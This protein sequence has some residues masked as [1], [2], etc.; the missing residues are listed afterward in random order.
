VAHFAGK[1][2]A[3]L[4]SQFLLL[5]DVA[6]GWWQGPVLAGNTINLGAL[7]D[8]N[9]A[10]FPGIDGDGVWMAA[11]FCTNCNNPAPWSITVLQPCR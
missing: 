10:P 4:E 1:S 6:D 9:G 2:V 11:L 8:K 3:D 7:A 5:E